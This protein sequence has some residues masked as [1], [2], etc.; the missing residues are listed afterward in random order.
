M[1][2]KFVASVNGVTFTKV[3]EYEQDVTEYED[4][5]IDFCCLFLLSF[6]VSLF[7]KKIGEGPYLL[8]YKREKIF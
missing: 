4:R 3:F 7:K 5:L 2:Y 6:S 8:L 1:E